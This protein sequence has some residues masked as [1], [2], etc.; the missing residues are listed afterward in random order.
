MEMDP[1]KCVPDP[2]DNWLKWELK[3]ILAVH[4]YF[5]AEAGMR[6]RDFLFQPRPLGEGEQET[7]I[8]EIKL[9]QHFDF[10]DIVA[11]E[12]VV[13]DY[14]LVRRWGFKDDDNQQI[15]LCIASQWDNIKISG[16][17][18]KLRPEFDDKPNNR[19]TK[20]WVDVFASDCS[21]ETFFCLEAKR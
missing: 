5:L 15:S 16:R 6:A 10:P 19:L 21:F 3:E 12:L 11:S 9:Y 17:S 20:I 14:S 2:N 4:W 8:G 7:R 13:F 1:Q 18:F